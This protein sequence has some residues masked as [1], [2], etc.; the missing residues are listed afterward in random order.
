ML[1]ETFSLRAMEELDLPLRES[2]RTCFEMAV[3]FLRKS[4]EK[5]FAVKSLWQFLHLNF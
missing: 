3:I 2:M 5:E 4:M 1:S